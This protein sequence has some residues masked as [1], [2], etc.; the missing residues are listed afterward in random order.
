MGD[1]AVFQ[2]DLGDRE[3]FKREVI[4]WAHYWRAVQARGHRLGALLAAGLG[5]RC[6]HA[7]GAAVGPARRPESAV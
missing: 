4:D 7:A 6:G 1:Q 2:V 5:G 3:Q